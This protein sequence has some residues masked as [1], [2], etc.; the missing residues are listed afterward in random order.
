MNM[1][2]MEEDGRRRE[3]AGE[4]GR[5]LKTILQS[6]SN[7]SSVLLQSFFRL[8]LPV[9]CCLLPSGISWAE[10][11]GSTAAEFLKIGVS[12]RAMALGSSYTALVDDAYSLHWNPAGLTR[13]KH[14]KADF[15]VNSYIQSIDQ[16]YLAIGYRYNKTDAFGLG[17]NMLQ[18]TGIPRTTVSPA[19]VV[20]TVGTFGVRDMA[21]SLG[22]ARDVTG[23][24][25]AGATAKWISSAIASYSAD[26]YAFD[27]GVQAMPFS[28]LSLGI[29]V[30]NF[31]HGMKYLTT[32]DPLP[33]L[34]RFGAAG[35]L[36]RNRSLILTMDAH[37][38]R[39]DL[40]YF[41]FGCEYTLALMHNRY[42]FRIGYTSANADVDRGLTFGFGM[43][44]GRWLGFDYAFVPFGVLGDA[45][46]YSMS[47]DF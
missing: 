14:C 25:S 8:L 37:Q 32:R 35:Y 6:F 1:G 29:A 16:H 39:G 40:L 2:K 44:L 12:P 41:G 4:V 36:L 47:V 31:G 10:S 18:S 17:V 27:A 13:I 30:Q 42:S 20:S 19:G 46:R 21:F 15:Q 22:Y 24:L 23:W 7:P 11:T 3:K 5:G 34:M 33:L 28:F 43:K 45:H 38:A 26:A 9:A